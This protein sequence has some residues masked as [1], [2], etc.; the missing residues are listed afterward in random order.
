MTMTK[1]GINL[2]SNSGMLIG[3]AINPS[4]IAFLTAAGVVNDSTVYF[5]STAFEITGAAQYVALN[6]V[7]KGLQLLNLWDSNTIIHPYMGGTASSTKFNLIDPDNT[8]AAH[9]ITWAGGL[10]FGGFG[11]LP[12]GTTGQ[13]DPH[14]NPSIDLTQTEMTLS[15]YSRTSPV[16]DGQMMGARLAAGTFHI[17]IHPRLTGTGRFD[18]VLNSNFAGL[19]DRD[20]PNTLGLHWAVR[21]A[22]RIKLYKSK[23]LLRDGASTSTGLVNAKLMYFCS[24]LEPNPNINYT[25]RETCLHA[26]FN[27]VMSDSV[28][29]D[30]TDLLNN[31]QTDLFRNV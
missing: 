21:D 8:N 28:R 30:V 13:G 2:L 7:V 10:T 14:I 27:R 17:R 11:V 3:N 6:K 19:I 22:A 16:N 23:T 26:V 24:S 18:V 9:R 5:P 25:N 4:T 29:N 31:L 12:N 15:F 20:N 1:K